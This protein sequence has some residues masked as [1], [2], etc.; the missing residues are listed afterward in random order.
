MIIEVIDN[1]DRIT[2]IE[3]AVNDLGNVEIIDKPSSINVETDIKQG[4]N[5]FDNNIRIELGD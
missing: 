2:R 5:G 3:I 1:H 4:I